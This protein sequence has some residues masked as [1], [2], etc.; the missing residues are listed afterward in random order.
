MTINT[1][2]SVGDFAWQMHENKA[3]KVRVL[4]IITETTEC[5]DATRTSYTEV[6]YYTDAS[7]NPYNDIDLY[8]TKEALLQSL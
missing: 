7:L 5:L 2:L 4:K 3:R 8:K 6:K 1:E